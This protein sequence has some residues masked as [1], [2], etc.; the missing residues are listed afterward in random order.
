[1]LEVEV[2]ILEIDK[3]KVI[4]KLD[5]LG[6]IKVFEGE[7]IANY[8]DYPNNSL[9]KQ[10][11]TL[12]LRKKSDFAELTLKEEVSRNGAKIMDEHETKCEYEGMKS[13]LKNLGF[14]RTK[15]I[16]KYRI[17]YSLDK[18]HFELDTFLGI[19]TFLEIEAATKKELE[20]M[21]AVLGYS[22][23]DT[24]PWSGHDV[25]EYYNCKKK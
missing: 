15:K 20:E 11:K 3:Q 12:R 6:A 23:K 2:K 24:K 22:M 16:V 25:L 1:M 7:I 9:A 5:E 4:K 18:C 8:Y 13:I 14:E 10:K 21:V 19:P 17:S